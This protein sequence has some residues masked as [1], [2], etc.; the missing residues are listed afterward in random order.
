MTFTAPTQ[1]QKFV[2]RH[3]VGIE[4]LSGANAFPEASLDTVD[5]II[6][7]AGDFAAGKWAPLNRVG[8]TVGARWSPDGVTMPDG[9]Q[10]AY[11]AYVE[12]G[13][14]TLS[15]PTSHGGQGLPQTLATVVLEDLGAANMAFSLCP[16]LSAGAVEALKHHGSAQQQEQWLPK[17][18]TGE[19]T[20]TMNLT[21]PQAGSDVGALKTR[22]EPTGHGTFL[23]KGQKIYITFGE[24]DLADNIVHLVLARLPDAPPGTRGISLFLVPKC[25]ATA[26]STM[27]A[28]SPSSTS[29]ASTPR[30]PA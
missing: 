5:A 6:D 22:A 30:P 21:E 4:E 20:G 27:S 23:I 8:D 10:E 25:A 13:W 1:E 12:G 16:M 26:R 29:S 7:G 14:G 18:V 3:V 24:H 9:F 28:A 17:L 19:W 2:L 15:A 11:R